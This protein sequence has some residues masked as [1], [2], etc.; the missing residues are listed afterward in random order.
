MPA[1]PMASR[2]L[3]SSEGDDSDPRGSP[4]SASSPPQVT[5]PSERIDDQPRRFSAPPLPD[6]EARPRTDSTVGE[7]P[8]PTPRKARGSP[9]VRLHSCPSLAEAVSV[10]LVDRKE[11]QPLRVG[12]VLEENTSTAPRSAACAR[13]TKWSTTRTSRTTSTVYWTTSWPGRSGASTTRRCRRRPRS[14]SARGPDGRAA[15]F[16]PHKSKMPKAASGIESRRRC[17]VEARWW[18]RSRMSTSTPSY[19]RRKRRKKAHSDPRRTSLEERALRHV[20]EDLGD[21]PRLGPNRADAL[22]V[23]RRAAPTNSRCVMR[24]PFLLK[25]RV[26]RRARARLPGLPGPLRAREVVFS[27]HL[28]VFVST[29]Y[30]RSKDAIDAR[31]KAGSGACAR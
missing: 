1:S 16:D 27:A 22:A 7:L 12:T 11:G 18:G 6:V 21:G 26:I 2:L 10:K 9:L 25:T 15:Q 3:S 8:R 28:C 4:S 23:F 24:P 20:R 30:K 31:A 13:T 5:P 17:G 19:E 29:P 14:F